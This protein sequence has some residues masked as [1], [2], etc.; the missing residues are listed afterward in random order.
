MSLD[1]FT[2]Y[3]TI[4]LV[5]FAL[6]A[7]WAVIAWQHPAFLAARIWLAACL[8]TAAGGVVLPFQHTSAMPI[9]PAT[10]GN[11][12]VI[13][14][15]WLCWI[16]VRRFHG[17]AGGWRTAGAASALCVL[18]TVFF[19]GNAE[20]L[21]LVYAL[22]QS[23]PM[24]TSAA[25]LLGRSRR[26]A[27]AML[28]CVGI[29]VG[30]AGHA[31]VVAMNLWSMA[32]LPP[33]A[34]YAATAS[35]TMLGVVF[36]GIVWNFGFAVMTIG[37]LRDEVVELANL[38]PL[39]GAWNRRKFDEQLARENAR[40]ARTGRPYALLVL[41]LDHFK[42]VN[43]RLGHKGGDESLI[44]FTRIVRDSLR[45]TD[46]LARLGGDEFCVLIPDTSAEMA[47]ALGR[48]I[49]RTVR[50]TPLLH[51]GEAIRLSCSI[52]IA[53]WSP[54]TSAQPDAALSRADDALYSVKSAGRNGIAL[55]APAL[56]PDGADILYAAPD[57]EAEAV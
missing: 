54:E 12:L 25:F 39:T 23:A 44:H 24:L 45:E 33:F 30:L 47:H 19:F 28:S 20:A 1:F 51:G 57:V 14:G 9:L 17:I 31:M 50:D 36:S 22:G 18:L 43:D 46:L 27:G 53:A 26:T 38:D 35:V 4:I 48:R 6:S 40:S 13:L 37:C 52:G 7:V 2:L 15:F 32:G 56:A 34:D 55:A 42:S 16:G 3:I 49:A 10:A 11:G 8:L 21:S 41:D 5:S 29:G